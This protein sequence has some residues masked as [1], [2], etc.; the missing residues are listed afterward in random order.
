MLL[1]Y[2][3]LLDWEAQLSHDFRCPSSQHVFP[4]NQPCPRLGAA[5]GAPWVT[6]EHNNKFN[7]QKKPH[8]WV[9]MAHLDQQ[10]MLCSP[11]MFLSLLC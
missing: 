10:E 3:Q 8:I 1:F 6:H 4:G 2:G 7:V 5:L 9:Q 11:W